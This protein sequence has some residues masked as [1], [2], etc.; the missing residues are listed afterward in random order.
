MNEAGL[1][2]VAGSPIDLMC[3]SIRNLVSKWGTPESRSAP[4]TEV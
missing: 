1:S 4:P 2:T 3:C